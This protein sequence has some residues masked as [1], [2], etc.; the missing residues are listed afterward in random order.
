MFFK[1]LRFVFPAVAAA[2]LCACASNP[3]YPSGYAPYN[4]QG[5]AP[6]GYQAGYG[7]QP[8]QSYY[9]PQAQGDFRPVPFGSKIK[10]KAQDIKFI[11]SYNP[12][13]RVP[14][15]D[16]LLLVSPEQIIHKW[17][18]KRFAVDGTPDRHV[19]FLIKDASI[20]EENII[21]G[22]CFKSVKQQY[23]AKFEVTIQ[24]VNSEGTVLIE[25][26]ATAVKKEIIDSNASL[27]ARENLWTILMFDTVKLLSSR[28]DY[29]LG[30]PSFNDYIER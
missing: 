20:V 10:L 3:G 26:S 8:P 27:E 25:T 28:L 22:S 6:A 2:S 1:L 13:A 7:V 19:R 29:D 12:P 14:N 21:T 16:H 18:E 9:T 24:I 11:S 15:I 30:S 23:T 5:Y 4:N 17:A